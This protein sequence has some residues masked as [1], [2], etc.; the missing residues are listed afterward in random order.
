MVELQRAVRPSA[1]FNQ[2]FCSPCQYAMIGWNQWRRY[3][4]WWLSPNTHFFG[5]MKPQS[6]SRLSILDWNGCTHTHTFLS[7]FPATGLQDSVEGWRHGPTHS[8]ASE[9]RRD[10]VQSLSSRRNTRLRDSL[11][12]GSAGPVHQSESSRHSEKI[13]KLK[14]KADPQFKGHHFVKILSHCR[15]NRMGNGL[16][17]LLR[18]LHGLCWRKN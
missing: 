10:T 12:Q 16:A 14:L 2:R 18:S 13:G 4:T 5:L 17:C 3:G 8:P 6:P 1:L 11:F 9:S 15:L 7:R